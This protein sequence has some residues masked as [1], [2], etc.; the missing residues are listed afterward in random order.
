MC[1]HYTYSVVRVAI[2]F[3][4]HG[5]L[6]VRWVSSST[7]RVKCFENEW[8]MGLFFITTPV[9][10]IWLIDILGARS[11]E[12]CEKIWYIYVY[13]LYTGIIFG[14]WR[15]D[16]HTHARRCTEY[17][18]VLLYSSESSTNAVSSKCF[19][20]QKTVPTSYLSSSAGVPAR[21]QC[22]RQFVVESL[23]LHQLAITGVCL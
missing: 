9:E 16:T 11:T 6:L 5:G 10:L 21:Q 8:M 4:R 13:C 20:H 3:L 1:L 14:E 22:G 19:V 18:S 23:L 7:R 2:G 15:W 17:T 12:L